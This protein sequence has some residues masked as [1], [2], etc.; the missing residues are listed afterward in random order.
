MSVLDPQFGDTDTTVQT[1][2]IEEEPKANPDIR[3]IAGTSVTAEAA[4]VIVRQQKLDG[5]SRSV[6]AMLKCKP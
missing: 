4:Q 3:Y 1:K 2:L 5:K 6:A